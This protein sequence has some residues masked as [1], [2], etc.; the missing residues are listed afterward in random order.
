MLVVAQ[1]QPQAIRDCAAISHEDP[2]LTP[3]AEACETVKQMQH[4]LPNFVCNQ[5]TQRYVPILVSVRHSEER[6]P[7]DIVADTVTAVAT[8][9]DGATRYTDI[10]VNDVPKSDGMTDL[11]GVTVFGEFGAQLVSLFL[12]ENS[13]IFRFRE[14]AKTPDGDV[15]VFE[16][17]VPAGKNNSWVLREGEFSTQPPLEGTLWLS[18]KNHK[19]LEL[20]LATSSIDRSISADRVRVSTSFADVHFDGAGDFLLPSRSEAKMCSRDSL[21]TYNVTKWSGCKRF[22]AKT[23]I[24]E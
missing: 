5:E 20:N 19:I 13:V 3:L 17:E 24:L 12:D 18:K 2:R 9:E 15:L 16:F 21:C 14:E 6:R 8:Y 7:D 23:R 22:G 4:T 10:K 11:P 1:S